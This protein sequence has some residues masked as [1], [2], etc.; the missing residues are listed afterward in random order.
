MAIVIYFMLINCFNVIK[1]HKNTV[2]TGY[3]LSIK[4]GTGYYSL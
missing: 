1:V 3:K 2:F 4:G